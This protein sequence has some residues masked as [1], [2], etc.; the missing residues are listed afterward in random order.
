MRT[1][2]LGSI[3][4]AALALTACGGSG[5]NQGEVADLLVESASDEGIE[6]DEG[7]VEDVAGKLSD[8]DAQRI[9]DAGSDGDAVLSAEGE[10]LAADVDHRALADLLGAVLAG[11][12]RM[13][14]TAGD[15]TRYT[16][17]VDVLERFFDG[18]LV[19]VS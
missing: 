6:L 2:I 7:C 18:S 13:S 4:I 5:G 14:A 10:A 19:T 3:A 17:A 1:R 9:I 12:A 8:D 16:A 15:P 11:L